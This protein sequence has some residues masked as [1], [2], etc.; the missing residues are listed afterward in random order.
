MNQ[1]G[2]CWWHLVLHTLGSWLH[3]D[4]RGFRSRDHRVHCSGD[5]KNPP[6]NGEHA[7]LHDFHR[8]RSRKV[9]LPAE[10]LE[11]VGCALLDKCRQTGT[12]VRVVSAGPT[13]A[14]LLVEGPY[15]YAAAERFMGRLKQHA[16]HAIRHRVPGNVWARGGKPIDVRTIG[17]FNELL[18]Y[19]PEHA[20]TEGAWVW[21]E[22]RLRGD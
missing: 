12:P 17:H 11:V 8:R 19:I 22:P 5:Y 3:G 10:L 4:P 21:A 15:D 20:E 14:H 9:M 16:S 6:P 18:G 13:H 1:P 7:G 2:H